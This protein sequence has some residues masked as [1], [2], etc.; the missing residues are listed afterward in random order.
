MLGPRAQATI[1]P[2]SKTIGAL[3]RVPDSLPLASVGLQPFV[4]GF[5]RLRGTADQLVAF[6]DAHPDLPLEVAPPPHLLLDLVGQWTHATAA[7]QADGVDGTGTLVGI[8]DTG[9]DFTL[10]DF[11][12]PVTGHTRIAWLL[13]FSVPPPSPPTGPYK[14][15]EAKY[16][17][18]VYQGSDLE[19]LAAAGRNDV[20]LT[21]TVGHGTHVAS[22]AAG[23]GG[24]AGQYVGVAPGASL[25]IARITRDATDSIASDD[26]LSGVEF[27]FDRADAMKLPIAANL[28]IGSDFGPHDG[29]MAWE[30]ALAAYVGPAHPGRAL[31]V[32]AGNS[33][34]I[35]TSPVHANVYVPPGD[36]RSIAI[37]SEYGGTNAGQGQ[38]QVWVTMRGD[39]DLAVGLDGPDGTWIS[40]VPGDQTGSLTNSSYQAS[41]YNGSSVSQGQIP[42]GS[43]SAIVLW[44]GT[45]PQGTYSVTLTGHGVADLYVEGSGDAIDYSGGGIGF[46]DPVREGTINIPGTHPGIIAVG[47]TMNRAAWTSIAGGAVS[48]ESPLL[49]ARG[50]YGI[51]SGTYL[52]PTSGDV[53]WFSSA[54]PTVTGVPKPEI[55]AP[56]GAVIA[57]M[58]QQA[59]PEVL[60]SIFNSSDC[61]PVT[62]GG[63]VDDRC[64]QVDATHA[65]AAGTSMS[66]PQAAG[67][68]ALL[69]QKDATLTQDQ[70]VGLLQ[71]GAH[72]FRTGQPRFEDQ[73]GPGELDVAGSLDALE[74][75]Q[76]PAL[77]LPSRTTSW[78]MPG[79]DELMADGSTPLTAIV[80]LRTA[81]G[82]RRADLFDPSRLAAVVELD[83]AMLSALPPMQRRAPGV[84]F[85]T[86]T[87]PPG[88]GGHTL[89]IGANFDGAPIVTPVSIPIATDVWTANYPSQ[90][91]GSCRA[92]GTDRSEKTW[93]PL[94][95]LAL[96]V[97]A[98]RRK[99]TRV[100]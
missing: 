92:A 22:I 84:W 2:R 9:I 6:A 93:W 17:G 44:A 98:V 97:V 57:A 48:V 87:P 31:F 63:V 73:G 19:A 74:Q 100:A 67:T 4:S 85:F 43:H 14:D 88:L 68:A 16:G 91:T 99:R 20:T 81:D 5:A 62:D 30:Q 77:A 33:G 18:T 79:A 75:E 82:D 78:I 72:A 40:P 41:I 37:T 49:D 21:D 12:D 60:T 94:T 80:E 76:S 23:N 35:T 69:F 42:S 55:S 29:T 64:M 59:G 24:L 66:S 89:T 86:L 3:V 13:D 56:G 11:N 70:I 71:A 10:A 54:G 15:L 61:P 95:L 96:G 90:T 47:C 51:D 8:A 36:S 52:T 27:L 39:A 45:W 38:V 1:E 50:G 7:R 28:S 34:D 46:V 58:S 25:V 65:V 83:G 26:L 32:A 53:C